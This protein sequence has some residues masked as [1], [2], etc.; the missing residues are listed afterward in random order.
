MW[1]S[2]AAPELK[3]TKIR[4]KTYTGEC[5]P[6]VGAINVDI[7][8]QGQKAKGTLLVVKGEGPSL[9]GRDLL[10]K[11]HLNWWEIW[12]EVKSITV[13]QDILA[14]Y[15]DVFRDELG[16]L[17]GTLVKL[18]VDPNAQPRFFKPRTVPYAMRAKVEAELERLQQAG[19][20]EPV[21]SSDWAAP[22]VPVTKEDG[23]VRICGDYKLTINQASQLDTYPLPRIEARSVLD[24]CLL[25][26]SRVIVP[27]PGRAQVMEELH[28]AHPGVSPREPRQVISV[29]AWNGLCLGR[30]GEGMFTMSK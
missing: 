28:N 19:V 13:A 25:W 30:K 18:C 20:I 7:D 14:K 29:V 21:K 26:G 10:Q 23:D 24:G 15:A 6:L 9:L 1:S 2:E 4:L 12:G 27:P 11:V 3:E 16:T 22:I 17:K 8:Y 5:I